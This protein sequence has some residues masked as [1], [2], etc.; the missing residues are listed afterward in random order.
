MYDSKGS[1]HLLMI[2]IEVLMSTCTI[3]M[4]EPKK[5]VNQP[6]ILSNFPLKRHYLDS[7]RVGP[8]SGFS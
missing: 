7:L 1:C 6:M 2:G 5:G 3:L 8:R 4:I